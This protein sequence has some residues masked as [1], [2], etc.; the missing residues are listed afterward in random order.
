[1]LAG[2]PGWRSSQMLV[3]FEP[4]MDSVWSPLISQLRWLGSPSTAPL[5]PQNGS[6]AVLPRFVALTLTSTRRAPATGRTGAS[7]GTGIDDT[8]F[9][10]NT[11]NF[12]PSTATGWPSL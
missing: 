9:A 2:N 11:L 5:S 8:V 4:S 1:M 3:A 6:T 10:D 7:Y 12:T